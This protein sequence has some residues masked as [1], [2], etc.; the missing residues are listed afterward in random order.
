ML[1]DEFLEFLEYNICK[2]YLETGRKD[3]KLWC[4]SVELFDLQDNYSQE[5]VVNSKQMHLKACVGK[6]GRSHFDLHLKLGIMALTLFS[7]QL[8]MKRTVPNPRNYET[9]SIDFEKNVINIQL[10]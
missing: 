1:D 4:K 6:Y 8:D 2:A 10:L 3:T 5:F 9:F 7:K